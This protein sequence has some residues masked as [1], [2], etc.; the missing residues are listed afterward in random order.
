MDNKHK[1][2]AIL[3]KIYT[4]FGLF[5]NQYIDQS[6]LTHLPTGM[7]DL[8]AFLISDNKARC[9]VDTDSQPVQKKKT[10]IFNS[11]FFRFLADPEQ[12]QIACFLEQLKRYGFDIYIPETQTTSVASSSSHH[13][14]EAD[15]RL[16]PLTRGGLDLLTLTPV[17]S[18]VAIDLALG[19]NIP[20]DRIQLINNQFLGRLL[21]TLNHDYHYTE[22]PHVVSPLLPMHLK[23]VLSDQNAL[24][25]MLEPG[26]SFRLA[27]VLN[28]TIF[29]LIGQLKEPLFSRIKQKRGT[30]SSNQN[31]EIINRF[32]AQ[33]EDLFLSRL[34][35][36]PGHSPI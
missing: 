15:L 29:H 11:G 23:L 6:S 25:A 26:D 2:P 18:S 27:T 24:I 7:F 36:Q 8:P 20:N 5:Y 4:K 12:A 21:N 19:L 31:V 35:R 28:T 32:L 22:G 17:H 13:D 9:W 3:H 14:E 16:K 30:F 34:A 10:L 1:I 33:T